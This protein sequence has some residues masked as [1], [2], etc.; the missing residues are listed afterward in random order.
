V[1]FYECFNG[2]LSD[3]VHFQIVPMKFVE[4]HRCS[5]ISLDFQLEFS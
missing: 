4:L 1:L 5:S 2:T 3:Y